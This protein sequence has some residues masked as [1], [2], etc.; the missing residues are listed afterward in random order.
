MS[1]TGSAQAPSAQPL[2]GSLAGKLSSEFAAVTARL[3]AELYISSHFGHA[4]QKV[5]FQEGSPQLSPV[6]GCARIVSHEDPTALSPQRRGDL[7]ALQIRR[8]R[9]TSELP[10]MRWL[11]LLQET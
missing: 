11:R 1:P 7:F 5:L 9:D 2:P 6:R 3:S 10:A 8:S 4:L